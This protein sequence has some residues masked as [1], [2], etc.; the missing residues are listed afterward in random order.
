MHRSSI[1]RHLNDIWYGR[2]PVPVTLDWLSTLH[3]WWARRRTPPP[4]SVGSVP[5]IVVGN[6][7]AGG[8]GKTPVVRALGD[9]LRQAG[10]RVVVVA[11]GYGARPRRARPRWVDEHTWPSA[12]GDEPCMLAQMAGLE[13]VVCA[14]RARAVAAAID[15]GANVVISDDGLQNQGLARSHSVC[16]VDGIR[17]FGNERLLPAGPLRE[18]INRLTEFD[19]VVVKGGEFVPDVAHTRFELRPEALI[20]LATGERVAMDAWLDRSVLG[21]CGIAHPEGFQATLEALGMAVRLVAFPDHHRYQPSDLTGLPT[22]APIV[23]TEKDAVKI[24]ALAL[25]STT[26]ERVFVLSVSAALEPCVLS[27]VLAHV[28][29]IKHH[30]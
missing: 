27:S 5:V 15:A 2:Q 24:R 16:V 18:P 13:V 3:A 23:V 21:V 20:Q 30:D 11:R 17:G 12:V 25:P 9:A 4:V 19:Q 14:D 1:E 28:Q 29:R 10:H 22:D 6:L 7:V 8:A 26:L